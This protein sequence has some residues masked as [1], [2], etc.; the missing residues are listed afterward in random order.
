MRKYFDF[1]TNWSSFIEIYNTPI[2]QEQ[3]QKDMKIYC[4][5]NPYNIITRSGSPLY[6][7]Y[8][9]GDPL[10]TYSNTNYWYEKAENDTFHKIASEKMIENYKKTMENITGRIMTKKQA[11]ENFMV[12]CFD[13][14]YKQ[15]LPQT[16][17]I[18]S[19]L[20]FGGE[21]YLTNTYFK[22]AREFFPNSTLIGIYA[23]THQYVLVREENIVF[24]IYGYY[25]QKPMT[26][27]L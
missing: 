9:K 16:N 21:S 24:D 5:A 11:E 10:W 6:K 4:L 18:E 13:N 27:R 22:I 12:S 25:S 14:I 23:E 17:S 26:V 1:S 8:K 3:L 7:T 19:F 20:L 15:F 2:V